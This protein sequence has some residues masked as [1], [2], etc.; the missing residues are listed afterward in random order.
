MKRRVFIH[1]VNYDRSNS[2]KS[3]AID[4]GVRVPENPQPLRVTVHS[5]GPKAAQAI[6]F[7]K[8]GA[9]TTF[10]LSDVKT[11]CVAMIEW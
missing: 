11:Y 10:T 4:V 5:P 2:T 6:D 7:A 3:N 9:Y 1:V 8:S